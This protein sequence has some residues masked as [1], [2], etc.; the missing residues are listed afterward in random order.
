MITTGKDAKKGRPS[1]L[2]PLWLPLVEKILFNNL[3]VKYKTPVLSS[4][5]VERFFN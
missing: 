2:S 5:A 4:A 3:F 1:N